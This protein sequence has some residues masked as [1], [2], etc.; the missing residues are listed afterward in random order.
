M[1][2][3]AKGHAGG[4]QLSEVCEDHE[5]MSMP[6]SYRH[7]LRVRRGSSV[8]STLKSAAPSLMNMGMGF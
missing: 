1:P 6:F 7:Q 2:P 3:F 5:K 4:P 8:L